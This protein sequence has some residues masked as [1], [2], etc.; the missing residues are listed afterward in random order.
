MHTIP[1]MVAARRREYRTWWISETAQRAAVFTLTGSAAVALG[2][3]GL[4][5]LARTWAKLWF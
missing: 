2:L 5:A 4:V 3:Y 1:M